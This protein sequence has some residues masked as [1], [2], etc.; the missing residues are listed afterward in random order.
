[1][2]DAPDCCILIKLTVLCFKI[3]LSFEL[4]L[5]LWLIVVKRHAHGCG[6]LSTCER[7]GV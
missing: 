3:L 4:L 1:M 6:T 5:W 2:P 7:T